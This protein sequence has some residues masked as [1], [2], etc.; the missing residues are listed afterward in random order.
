MTP[1]DRHATS[2]PRASRR[3]RPRRPPASKPARPPA[4]RHPPAVPV[5]D[6]EIALYGTGRREPGAAQLDPDAVAALE[7][8]QAHLDRARQGAAA[9]AEQRAARQAA[10]DEAGI[11]EPISHAEATAQA[12]LQ[13]DWDTGPASGGEADA[14]D[15]LEI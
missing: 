11:N 9:P 1:P 5:T 3:S 12:T 6:A 2:V 7:S 10:R 13:A 4:A 8:I 14:S 15:G